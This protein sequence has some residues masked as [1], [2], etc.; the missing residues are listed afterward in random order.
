MA[1]SALGM[2]GAK[3]TRLQQR[4]LLTAPEGMR[5]DSVA[6]DFEPGAVSEQIQLK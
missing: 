1:L 3:T 2:R 5:S 4:Q 6:G